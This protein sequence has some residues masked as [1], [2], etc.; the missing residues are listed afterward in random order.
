MKRIIIKS[1]YSGA[2]KSYNFVFNINIFA[3]SRFIVVT[4]GFMFYLRRIIIPKKSLLQFFKFI[5]NMFWDGCYKYLK[6]NFT[7]R[8]CFNNNNLSFWCE[9]SHFPYFQNSLHICNNIINYYFSPLS[10][11]H[12]KRN[13][14]LIFLTYQYSYLYNA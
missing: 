9:L 3:Y 13:G 6:N 2:S 8:L 5:D 12:C 4:K 1:S 14:Y 11:F 10:I 7:C